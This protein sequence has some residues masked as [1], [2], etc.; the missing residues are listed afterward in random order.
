[1]RIL[2][3]VLPQCKVHIEE[4]WVRVQQVIWFLCQERLLEVNKMHQ[5]RIV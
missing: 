3:V 5:L 2:E 1:M 4:G